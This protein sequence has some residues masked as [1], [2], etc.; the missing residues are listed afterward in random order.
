MDS[1][2][3]TTLLRTNRTHRFTFAMPGEIGKNGTRQ[4]GNH[5]GNHF[6]PDS[7]KKI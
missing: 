7:T 2:S 4:G 5:H 3:T 1:E 6:M